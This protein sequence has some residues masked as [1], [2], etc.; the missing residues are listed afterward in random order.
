MGAIHFSIDTGLATLFQRELSLQTFVETGT[1][2]GNTINSMQ[3]LFSRIFSVELSPHYHAKAVE[4]FRDAKGVNLALG[5]SPAFLKNKREEF[6]ASPVLFWLDAHWCSAEHTSGQDSQ[7]PLLQEIEAIGPLHPDSVLLIDDARLYLCPPPKPHRCSDW[8]DWHDVTLALLKAG[9][10]HR[11]MV[12]NDVV[13][14]YPARVEKKLR[15]YAFANGVDWL[16]IANRARSH[17]RREQRRA[18]WKFW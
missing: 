4:R 8:P 5:E 16:G 13:I 9:V 2:E 7:S 1:F 18:R 3:P 14:L 6:K 17:E 15:E 10:A 11:L 12:L